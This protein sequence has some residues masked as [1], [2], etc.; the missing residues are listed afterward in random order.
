MEKI[1]GIISINK[2]FGIT[3]TQVVREIKRSSMQKKVG[4]SGTL[5]PTAE[6]VL[7]ICIGQGTRVVE[8]IMEFKKEYIGT[9]RL[10][11]STDTFDSMGKILK[12]SNVDSISKKIIEENLKIFYGEIKQT[13]PMF[14]ALKNKGK[15]LYDIARSGN[16]IQLTP[17]NVSVSKIKLIEWRPPNAKILVQCSK[18]FYM[19][20]LAEDLGKILNVGAHLSYLVRKSVGPFKINESISLEDAIESFKENTWD[21]YLLNPDFALGKIPSTIL[22]EIN[23]N[24]IKTGQTIFL[25]LPLEKH[26]LGDQIKA[27][28]HRGNFVGILSKISENGTWKPDKVFASNQ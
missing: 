8:N 2:P 25:T 5:D 20:S 9:I 22:D 16:S 3:S 12:I 18:G 14:S 21:K 15:R 7:P 19:R 24:K 28:G 6:G 13:P 10:G 11:I 27:Y 23:E 26:K 1:H 17:R 4:H